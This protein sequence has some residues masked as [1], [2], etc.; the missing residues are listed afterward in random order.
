MLLLVAGVVWAAP[1]P[2]AL[3]NE[4]N[5]LYR[6]GDFESARSRY[7]EAVSAGAQ[8]ARLYYNLGNAC[9]KA[10]HIGDA[11]LWF[12]RARRLEPRDE[13]IRANLDFVN[14]VKQDRETEEPNA[15]WGALVAAIGFPTINEL[16]VLLAVLAAAA[17][18]LSAWRLLRP[19]PARGPL[20]AMTFSTAGAAG[21]VAL[22]LAGR[23]YA[24]ESTTEAVVVVRE[25]TA[26]SGPDAAQTAVFVIHEGTKVQLSRRE[27]GWAL[28]RLPS[29]PLGWLP[30]SALMAI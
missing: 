16:C 29:G 24:Q 4:A 21:L 10:G 14:A 19:Q 9:F 2:A 13:D 1:D 5:A 15:L 3:Y 28:V 23:I 6:A 18:A 20:L 8:D 30:D 17:V 25:A 26:R 27:A 7:L 11:V 12:E 22:L